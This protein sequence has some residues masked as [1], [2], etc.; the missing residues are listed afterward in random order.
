MAIK[1]IMITFLE[2]N[3]FNKKADKKIELN[4]KIFYNT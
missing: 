1:N 3:L 2:I 4:N